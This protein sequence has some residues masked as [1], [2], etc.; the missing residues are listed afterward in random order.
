[1]YTSVTEKGARKVSKKINEAFLE[2]Y[3]AL[4]QLCCKKLGTAKMGVTEYITRLN[5]AR[6][7]PSRDEI[8]PRLV[9]YRNIRKSL[10][11]DAGA[12]STS[13]DLTKNDVKWMKLFVKTMEK[14]K[15]PLS[16]YLRKARRHAKLRRAR[17]TILITLFAITAI[18]AVVIAA[19]ALF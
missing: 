13:S 12:L 14:K 7:A 5:N 19:I 18:A 11:H 15:D 17:K 4:D 10:V 2:D 6:F 3:I 9:K 1:M 16:L 8:L